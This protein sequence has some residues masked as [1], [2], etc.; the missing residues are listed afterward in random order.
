VTPYAEY[1]AKGRAT[2]GVRCHRFLRGED[3]LV[4]AFAG[5]EPARAAAANGV[6]IELPAAD[7]RRDGSGVAMTAVIAH[8]AGPPAADQSSGV[9]PTDG[10]AGPDAGAS[11]GGTDGST[12]GD[13]A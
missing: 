7:G 1:P 6:A 9:T 13:G 12:D 8:V 10:A 2:G 11:D 3:T 5:N 4:L